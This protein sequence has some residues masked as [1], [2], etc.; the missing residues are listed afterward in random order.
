MGKVWHALDIHVPACDPQL[1]DLVLAEL[2]DFQPT[3]IQEFDEGAPKLRAFFTSSAPRDD[4]AR[5][6]AVEFG[7]HLFVEAISVEDEDWAARS[8]S[9]LHAIT[10]GRL[11]VAPPWEP[12]SDPVFTIIVNPSVGFG[13]GHHATTRLVL[14]ALQNLPLERRTVLD[15][16]CGS[17]VLAIAAAK[18]GAASATGI[19][20][21]ADALDNARENA[22]LNHSGDSVQI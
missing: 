10:I 9:R 3:A 2:D 8:Q 13:T 21:D 5:A 22:G 15:I 20:I 6:L 11:T 17:G 14:L 4:A 18:L 16:G 19:D 7:T 1:Q 12:G